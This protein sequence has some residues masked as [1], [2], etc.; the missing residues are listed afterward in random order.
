MTVFYF[1]KKFTKYTNLV[2]LEYVYKSWYWYYIKILVNYQDVCDFIKLR[3]ENYND[4]IIVVKVLE[5]QIGY[6]TS[7]TKWELLELLISHKCNNVETK[8][9][10]FHLACSRWEP[11]MTTRFEQIL[12]FYA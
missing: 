5:L 8:H 2:S 7:T 9:F 1:D 4:T 12:M 10:I 11:I 6:S 3:S